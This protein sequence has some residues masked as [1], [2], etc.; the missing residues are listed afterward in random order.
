MSAISTASSL[1]NILAKLKSVLDKHKQK[2][3]VGNKLVNVLGDDIDDYL[4][5]FE[6]IGVI[7]QKSLVPLIESTGDIASKSQIDKLVAYTTQVQLEYSGLL[8][9]LI[10]LAKNCSLISGIEGFMKSLMNTDIMIGDFVKVLGNTYVKKNDSVK[11]EDDFYV[12]F[13]LNEKQVLKDLEVTDVDAVVGQFEGYVRIIKKKVIPYITVSSISRKNRRN[14]TRSLETL[15]RTCKRVK[16]KKTDIADLR[17][18]TPAK[19]LPIV[20]LM[21][22]SLSFV[23]RYLKRRYPTGVRR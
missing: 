23:E 4:T 1:Y 11:I 12:F 8:E 2:K 15:N 5:I 7:S 21:E 10:Q 3:D 13:K 9:I 6:E 22:E 18:Y 16:V 17:V 19:L 20:V 14:F